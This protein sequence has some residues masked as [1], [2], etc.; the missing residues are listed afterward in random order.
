MRPKQV[1]WAYWHTVLVI[2]EKSQFLPPI[3]WE[4]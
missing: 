1:I 2:E 3:Y 4:V